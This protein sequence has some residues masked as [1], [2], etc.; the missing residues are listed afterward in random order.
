MPTSV[1]EEIIAY[2]QKCP[3]DKYI[4][5]TDK[6]DAHR[7]ICDSKNYKI[8][9]SFAGTWASRCR[10]PRWCGTYT[11]DINYP[12]LN[13]SQPSNQQYGTAKGVIN[14]LRNIPQLPKPF[15]W[16]RGSTKIEFEKKILHVNPYNLYP[17]LQKELPYTEIFP[18]DVYQLRDYIKEQVCLGKLNTH[19]DLIVFFEDYQFFWNPRSFDLTYLP[20]GLSKYEKAQSKTTGT[21]GYY[22]KITDTDIIKMVKEFSKSYF[23]NNQKG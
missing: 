12:Q 2:L 23:K 7:L 6:E 20:E 16:N 15:L 18:E 10:E 4:F 13:N 1:F 17:L 11:I 8:T 19:Y 3:G 21:T 22:A 5:I 9:I 14:C